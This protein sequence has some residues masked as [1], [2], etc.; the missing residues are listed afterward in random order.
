MNL[1]ETA[2]GGKRGRPHPDKALPTARA[3]RQTRGGMQNCAWRPQ[4][5]GARDEPTGVWHTRGMLSY[6]LVVLI[7]GALIAVHEFG[8]LLLAKLCRIPIAEFS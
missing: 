6:L 2:R 8:H 3:N 7:L 4:G 1:A 5:A